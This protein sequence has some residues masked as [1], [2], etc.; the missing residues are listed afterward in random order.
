[1]E[2]LAAGQAYYQQLL[3]LAKGEKPMLAS[4]ARSG[5]VT[6]F[7]GDVLQV[8]FKS[9][10]L[11]ERMGSPDFQRYLLAALAQLAGRPLVLE[12]TVAG[13]PRPAP[14]AA[15][16]PAPAGGEAAPQGVEEL[17]PRLRQ[18]LAVLGGRVERLSQ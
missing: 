13:Q 15:S 3:E 5:T 7:A 4:C 16:P 11:A 17:P 12:C 9:K 6:G 1:M 10:F 2:D 14:A 8:S 18:G